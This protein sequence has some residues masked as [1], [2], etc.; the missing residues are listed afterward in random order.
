MAV[1]GQRINQF[2]PDG[3][4][5]ERNKVSAQKVHAVITS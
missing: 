2:I 5:V 1:W 3:E 4:R